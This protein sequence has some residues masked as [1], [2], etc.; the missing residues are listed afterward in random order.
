MKKGILAIVICCLLLPF[1]ACDPD[2]FETSCE[3]CFQDKPTEGLLSI[4]VSYDGLN[5]IP[6]KVVKDR[7]LESGEI[8]II[9]TLSQDVAEFWVDVG[10]IYSVE[11]EYLVGDRIVKV[12]DN[13]KV[14]VFLDDTNCDQACWRPNDGVADCRIH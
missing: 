6:I 10:E 1:T 3:N 11:A 9:D 14:S 2:F 7:Q 4:Q 12:I 8:I 5:K 13:D